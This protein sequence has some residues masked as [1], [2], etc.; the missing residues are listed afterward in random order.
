[1]RR[2]VW[3]ALLMLMVI[4]VNAIPIIKVLSDVGGGG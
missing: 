4:S 1:M 3:Y 2:I